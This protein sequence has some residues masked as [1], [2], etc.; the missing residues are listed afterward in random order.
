MTS[1]RAFWN[2][3]SKAMN[4]NVKYDVFVS[5]SRKDYVDESGHPIEGS[6]IAELL[7]FLDGNRITYWIDKEGIYSGS[8][9]VEVIT[10]AITESKMLIFVSS[11][12]SNASKYTTGEIFEA[13]DQDKLIV[14]FKI[15]ES[16][17]NKRYRMMVRPLDFIEYYSNHQLAF[18]SLL[19]T[20]NA[21]KKEYEEL[22]L[23]EERKKAEADARRRIAEIEKEIK[24]EVS[25]YQR[26]ASNLDIKAHQIVEKQKQIGNIQKKC[27][28]CTT[29][30][31]VESKYCPKCGWSFNPVFDVSP[32]GDKDHLFLMQS[33]WKSLKDSVQIKGQLN[34]TIT[35]LKSSID[36]KDATIESL[37]KKVSQIQDIVK[38][39][40][41]VKSERS[42]LQNNL[43][44]LQQKLK[45][46]ESETQN[47]LEQSR[48]KEEH[49]QSRIK[50]LSQQL[51]STDIKLSNKDSQ[52][53]T[54]E[55]TLSNTKAA[56]TSTQQKLQ[57]YKNSETKQKSNSINGHEYVDLGL[58]V[59]W[60]TCN[61]GASSPEDC[62]SYFAWGETGPK[63]SYDW[64]N[65]KYRTEGDSYDNVKF[66]K[67]VAESEYGSVD[68]RT[69]LELAD[70]A[71]RVNWGG[72]WRMPTLD[73]IK[74][75]KEQ[76]SWQ[77]TTVNGHSGYRVTSKRNGRSIFLPAAGFRF[78][79]SSNNV[80]SY[81]YYW[82]SSLYTGYSDNACYL[83]FDGSTVYWYG[84]DR[85][86][87]HSVRAVSE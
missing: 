9:F 34:E 43:Y 35:G 70:D 76:C 17:Y 52:I 69:G 47:M 32:N 46:A 24:N 65:L 15:D 25:E 67:Y 30:L 27:P 36:E 50:D 42:E 58:S 23:E 66:S 20:I 62:G 56:L 26:Y 81:G 5:Y 3:K 29:S 19:K 2:S 59:K 31:P 73:E 49:L 6:P 63:D 79:P 44:D 83:G 41:V 1:C 37:H 21:C 75:L 40:E 82:S 84:S 72:S 13:L 55:A 85:R 39:L 71:A 7:R 33:N 22:L 77:W 48:A 87:G 8:E 51:A 28:I 38:N 53:A 12:H 16:P 80:G 4:L 45:K 57:V 10:D 86:D 11:Q 68:N 14:P 60:A 18:E 64:E 61:V 74:E 54:L 78:G